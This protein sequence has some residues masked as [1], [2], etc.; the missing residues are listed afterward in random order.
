MDETYVMNQVKEDLCYVST[1][2]LKD[3]DIARYETLRDQE[4]L[5]VMR[6]LMRRNCV[7][8]S[9]LNVLILLSAMIGLIL[10][11][12]SSVRCREISRR[13]KTLKYTSQLMY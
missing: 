8:I 11:S 12:T 9:F 13:Y 6:N 5:Y 2:F 1:N 4:E 10:Q 7:K 3:M